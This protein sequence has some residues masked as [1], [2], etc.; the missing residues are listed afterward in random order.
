MPK[1]DIFAV[2]SAQCLIL[3]WQSHWR[4]TDCRN[5]H[6][7]TASVSK[8][9]GVVFTYGAWTCSASRSP[10]STARHPAI[11]LLP[12]QGAEGPQV[13]WTSLLPWPAGPDPV[14][15]LSDFKLQGTASAATVGNQ[16]HRSR[17]LIRTPR[18]LEC[19]HPARVQGGQDVTSHP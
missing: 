15:C 13:R 8:P 16:G 6:P 18:L 14:L 12:P 9:Q 11:G 7:H 4:S 2:S 5:S 1:H 17:L 3:R 10:A 19:G